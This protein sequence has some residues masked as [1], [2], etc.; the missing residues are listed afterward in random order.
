MNERLY[1]RVDIDPNEE[2]TEPVEFVGVYVL[3]WH[4]RLD[5]PTV[6]F[7]AVEEEE[8]PNYVQEME[9]KF[10]GPKGY[11][12]TNE[13]VAY[14]LRAQVYQNERHLILMSELEQHLVHMNNNL[15]QLWRMIGNG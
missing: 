2:E 14:A 9:E 11:E 5:Q 3:K 6:G 12:D 7:Y 1:H 8:T 13:L 4:D 10:T 15:V